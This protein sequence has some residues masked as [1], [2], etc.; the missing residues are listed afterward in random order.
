MYKYYRTA[1]IL[2]RQ[3]DNIMLD[4]KLSELLTHNNDIIKRHAMGIYKTLIKIK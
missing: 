1:Q 3:I 4:I 2:K